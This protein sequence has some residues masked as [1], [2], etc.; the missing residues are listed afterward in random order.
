MSVIFLFCSVRRARRLRRASRADR[1]PPAVDR[2]P[3]RLLRAVRRQGARGHGQ[4]R[5]PGRPVGHVAGFGRLVV[6]RPA[7]VARRPRRQVLRVH[8][9]ATAAGR[10]RDVVVSLQQQ[11]PPAAH[12]LAA[13]AARRSPAETPPLLRP[14]A[15]RLVRRL[16]LT[17]SVPPRPNPEP[18]AAASPRSSAR[19]FG[20]IIPT[21]SD[22]RFCSF[23][24]V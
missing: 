17:G 8:V 21:A 16:G 18:S 1:G 13:V 14:V 3:Q 23:L 22:Q 9:L 7:T 4:L 6:V 5:L 19:Q 12:L 10:G 2:G 24:S 11:Q 15:E 20:L